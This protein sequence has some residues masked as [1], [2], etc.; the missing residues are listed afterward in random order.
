MSDRLE[1]WTDSRLQEH[2]RILRDTMQAARAAGDVSTCRA[3]RDFVAA[4]DAELGRR[5]P[6]LGRVLTAADEAA[7]W[8]ACR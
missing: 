1:H 7:A 6:E 3:C 5:R 4:L 8:E 2:R